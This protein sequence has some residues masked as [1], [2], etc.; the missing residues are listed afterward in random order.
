MEWIKDDLCVNVVVMMFV[1]IFVFVV[2]RSDNLY[3]CVIDGF[4]NFRKFGDFEEF[5]LIFVNFV[6][7]KWE[8]YKLG[9]NLWRRE[10]FKSGSN[11]FRNGGL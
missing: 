7:I 1:D 8:F 11:C 5:F 9:I 6:N 4:N 3:M 2:R 10:I